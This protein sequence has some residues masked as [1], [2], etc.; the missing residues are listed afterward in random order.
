MYIYRLL[1][2]FV[3]VNL[4]VEHNMWEK[5]TQNIVE[6]TKEIRR[7]S[8]E[9]Y[10]RHRLHQASTKALQK[11]KTSLESHWTMRTKSTI[12]LRQTTRAGTSPRQNGLR[13]MHQPSLP[14][15]SPTNSRFDSYIP[16]VVLLHNRDVCQ[17][18]IANC[19]CKPSLVAKVL[20]DGCICQF[21][22]SQRFYRK[23][24]IS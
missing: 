6:N 7:S 4:H 17:N 14:G 10:H 13:L 22:I 11:Y 1:N 21:V 20:C 23:I 24:N 19:H 5:Q 8:T 2:L 16:P 15:L 12:I 9:W 3:F 18:P